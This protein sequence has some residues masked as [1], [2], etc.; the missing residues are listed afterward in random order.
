MLIYVQENILIDESGNPVLTD[1]G[2]MMRIL[3]EDHM[4]ETANLTQI[5]M[6]SLHKDK[7]SSDCDGTG[8]FMSKQRM[9][10]GEQTEADEVWAIGMTLVQ[11]RTQPYFAHSSSENLCAT[12][13]ASNSEATFHRPLRKRARF[14][15]RPPQ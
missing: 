11:V 3:R 13:L 1:F 5:S 6:I 10:N 12:Y 14:H 15:N 7:T 4:A 8:W 2:S 9:M